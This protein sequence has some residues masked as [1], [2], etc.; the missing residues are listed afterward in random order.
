MARTFRTAY[1]K[2]TRQG[3]ATEGPTLT[4]QN[5]KTECDINH[6]LKRYQKTGL[7]DHVNKHQGNYSDISDVPTYQ[8]AINIIHAA[9]ASFSSLPSSM[10]KQF[11]NDPAKFLEFVHNPDNLEAMYE[12]GLANRPEQAQADP[13]PVVD[14]VVTPE[15]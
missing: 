5:H 13:P 6:L 8:E 10:R 9:S 15:A 11:D 12:M 4:K 7:I 1:S 14:P 3:Y 2:R